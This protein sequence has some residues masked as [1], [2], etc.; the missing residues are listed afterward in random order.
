[1]LYCLS[2]L[3]MSALCSRPRT[4]CIP[5]SR[6]LLLTVKLSLIIVPCVRKL[7]GCLPCPFIDPF[8]CFTF[9]LW[10]HSGP[11]PLLFMPPY[12][13]ETSWKWLAA[14]TGSS[15]AICPRGPNRI[16]LSSFHV[17]RYLCSEARAKWIWNERAGLSWQVKKIWKSLEAA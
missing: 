7:I 16:R 13:W 1:M 15:L 3:L 10:G 2:L 4:L 8:S 14:I 9:Y 12:L 6:G 11:A 17:L 5:E